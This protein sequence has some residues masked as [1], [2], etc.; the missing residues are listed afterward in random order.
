MQQLLRQRVDV[1][2]SAHTGRRRLLKDGLV[3]RRAEK[4]PFLTRRKRNIRD[5]QISC[6]RCRDW[7]AE[8]W[9]KVIFSDESPLWLH[10][11][12]EKKRWTLPSVLCRSNSKASRDHVWGHFSAKGV[13][14]EHSHEIKYGT[15]IILRE[16]LPPNIHEVWW[17]TTSFP[18][19]WKNMS[20]GKSD[21]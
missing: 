11:K 12:A 13:G 4:K 9:G 10:K 17:W 8:D 15:K 5:W 3:S 7:T 21:N 6:K 1:C 14:H 20:K 2:S 18:A 16:L 19:W